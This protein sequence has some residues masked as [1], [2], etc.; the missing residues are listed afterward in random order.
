M[1]PPGAVPSPL[2]PVSVSF[3]RYEVPL[4][5][6]PPPLYDA[7]LFSSWEPWRLRESLLSGTLMAPPWLVAGLLGGGLG[8][9][10][11]APP[12]DSRIGPPCPS[13]PRPAALLSPA[14]LPAT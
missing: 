3:L 1:P 13:V 5:K 14:T 4:V 7:E 6:I 9:V 10:F 8:E 2:F 11:T 12:V